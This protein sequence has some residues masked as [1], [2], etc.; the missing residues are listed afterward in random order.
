MNVPRI[1]IHHRIGLFALSPLLMTVL[2]AAALAAP[3]PT[4]SFVAN[5]QTTNLA[6]KANLN[7]ADADVGK[8][9]NVYVAFQHDNTWL[10]H[11]GSG[12]VSA[13]VDSIPVYASGPLASRSIDVTR[14]LDMS[15]LVGGQVYV[16]YGVTENDMVTNNKFA[17]VYTVA[18]STTAPLVT[19]TIIANG[20]RDV[21]LNTAVA[22][23]F[24]A[25]MDPATINLANFTLMQGTTPVLGNV[26]YSGRA[27]IFQPLNPLLASS[28]YTATIKGGSN[29]VRDLTGAVLGKDVVWS[30]TTAAA[31]TPVVVATEIANGATGV[32]IYKP[33]VVKFS[34]PM[35][36]A[37]I[38]PSTFSVTQGGAPVPGTVSF[39]EDNS[40]TFVPAGPMQVD[41]SYTATIKG[42]MNGAQSVFG[43]ALSS[44]YSW[45]WTTG[46]PDPSTALT[47]P[48]VV[49]TAI[50]NGASGVAPAAE[51]T[52]T[53]NEAM[54]ADSI[55]MNNVLLVRD[56]TPVLGNVRYAD[57]VVSFEPLGGMLPN[58]HYSLT[59]KG[60]SAGVRDLTGSA[61][62]SD[63][64]WSWTTAP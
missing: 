13:S 42:G 34:E 46:V 35:R 18:A 32:E 11:N 44:D 20:S 53:F 63:Y 45:R 16:G 55:T 48:I 6:L 39:S 58:S 40:V 2:G 64:V 24:N 29:G 56:G 62:R 47:A 52:A 33:V 14:D 7:I 60:G 61:L 36:F 27:L 21:A 25:D 12:W 17:M 30:W 10:F 1:N 23:T 43:G 50:A 31:T 41:A 8:M 15:G 9:G 3:T 19:G 26:R 28:N 54:K 59:I 51:I 37:S 4:F 57:M 22:A 38:S 49:G 5:G